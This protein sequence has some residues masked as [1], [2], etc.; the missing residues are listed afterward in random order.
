MKINMKTKTCLQSAAIFLTMA[1]ADVAAGYTLIPFTGYLQGQEDDTV[2]GN[3]PQEIIVHGTVTG[4]ATRLGKFTMHY[5]LT[6]S[7]PASSSSGSARLIAANGDMIF[8]SVVGQAMAVPDTADLERIVEY[9]TITGGTG[10]FAGANGSFTVER[11]APN[12]ASAPTFG[13][14]QG[15]IIS[16]GAAH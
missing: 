14:F 11:L 15:T 9:N 4:L 3:P 5:D 8:T 1:L 16:P 7:L 6:V 2:V 12:S 13:F 10:R